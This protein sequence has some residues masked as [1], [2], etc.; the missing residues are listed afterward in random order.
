MYEKYFKYKICVIGPL[1]DRGRK[2]LMY[3]P[4]IA[5]LISGLFPFLV[6]YYKTCSPKVILES[7]VRTKFLTI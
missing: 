6:V 5:H 2:L 1:S 3:I 7:C 4:F